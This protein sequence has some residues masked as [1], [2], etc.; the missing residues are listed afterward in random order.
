MKKILVGALR[1]ETNSFSPIITTAED[2]T[3][4]KGEEMLDYIA[5]TQ[6]FLEAN[7]EIIPTLYAS[8]LPNGKVHEQCYREYTEYI[9]DHISRDVNIHGVWLYL[10][11]AM[12]VINIGSGE[13]FLVSEIR[14]K[15][16][17]NIPIAVAMDFHANNTKQLMDSAN[18]IYGYRTAPHTDSKETQIKSA[19][20]LLKCIEEDILPRPIMI[21]V[22]LLFPGELVTTGIEPT[23]S[24][25]SELNLI[26]KKEDILCSSLFSGMP[27]ADIPNNGATVVVVGKGDAKLAE[28]EATHLAQMFWDIRKKFRFEEEASEPEE[29]IDKA[30]NATEKPV[31]ISDSGDNVTAGAPGDNAYMLNMLLNKKAKGV[32]V[33]GITDRPSVQLCNEYNIG[34]PVKLHIGGTLDKQ[35]QIAEVAGILKWKGALSNDGEIQTKAVV[36]SVKDIDVIIT[37]IRH[38]FTSPNIIEGAGIKISDYKIIVVKLGYL[39][40]DLRKISKR[41]F[42]AL[43]PG[44]SCCDLTK[45]EYKKTRRPMYPLDE[46]F[47]WSVNLDSK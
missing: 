46:D 11:G 47:R 33:A 19:K 22:P 24:L 44:T 16:G 27:W 23:K 5:A 21:R 29:S 15:V 35:S 9:L 28:K 40:A 36:V 41:S 37:D 25:I 39:F 17:P 45:L 8:A 30:L 12:D 13:A 10:H 6:V 34:D 32:L 43:T 20:I 4:V 42:L 14:R 3:V 7:I 26:D 1:Q 18:I 31:F 38:S 2:F